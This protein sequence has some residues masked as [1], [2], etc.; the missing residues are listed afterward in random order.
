MSFGLGS[1]LKVLRH[2]ISNLHVL[3]RSCG[4][5]LLVRYT[6]V[7]VLK[8]WAGESGFGVERVGSRTAS[9]QSTI[10][11]VHEQIQVGFGLRFCFDS[12][13]EFICM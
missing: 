5:E 10:G 7:E 6:C 4:D 12:P 11:L 3:C 2:A 8:T 13:T 1:V 9:G